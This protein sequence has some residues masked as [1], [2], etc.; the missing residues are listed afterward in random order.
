MKKLLLVVALTFLLVGC[1]ATTKYVDVPVFKQI[2]FN[3]PTRPVLR[4]AGPAGFDKVS[5]DV[6]EDLLDMSSYATQCE[7]ILIDLKLKKSI[8]INSQK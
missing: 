8:N 4:S 3:M 5:K 1:S 6:E 7:N 2:D